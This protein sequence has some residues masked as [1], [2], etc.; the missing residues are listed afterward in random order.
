MQPT[1]GI[2]GC[3]PASMHE[4]EIL[5]DIWPFLFNEITNCSYFPS[6]DALDNVGAAVFQAE[7]QK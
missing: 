5:T 4:V 3:R 7:T 2:A 6:A 1:S